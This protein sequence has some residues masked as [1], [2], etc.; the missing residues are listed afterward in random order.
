IPLSAD[1]AVL[2]ACQT[3]EGDERLGEGLMGLAWAFQA[4]GC[5]NVVASLWNIDDEATQQIMVE[6]YKALRGNK[7]IDDAM[8]S[9]MLSVRASAR[10]SS[11]YFWAGFQILG[12]ASTVATK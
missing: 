5:P 4:A 8:R 3:A 12:P 1:L 7:R 2:S 6:F 11:P 10:T 9:A